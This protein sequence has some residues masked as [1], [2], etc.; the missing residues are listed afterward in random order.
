MKRYE[1]INEK[2]APAY[3]RIAPVFMSDGVRVF[4]GEEGVY[5]DIVAFCGARFSKEK[6]AEK[7]IENHL[8]TKMELGKI[9]SYTVIEV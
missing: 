4:Y 1:Y 8:K 6:T 3:Y 2:N 5:P 7:A 9:K